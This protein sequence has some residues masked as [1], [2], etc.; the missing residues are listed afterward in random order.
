MRLKADVLTRD[1][2]TMKGIRV[3]DEENQDMPLF[4]NEPDFRWFS[5]S[6]FKKKGIVDKI[7]VNRPTGR[8][9][10]SGQHL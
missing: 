10:K 4:N 8:T 5:L 9:P 7:S 3:I 6:Y 2:M 1:D